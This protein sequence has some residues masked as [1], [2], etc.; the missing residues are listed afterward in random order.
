MKNIFQIIICLL[1]F[2]CVSNKKMKFNVNIE[3]FKLAE[4][5]TDSLMTQKIDTILIF[6]KGCSGCIKG[7]RYSVYVFWKTQDTLRMIRRF[8]NYFGIGKTIDIEDLTRGFFNHESEIRMT[9]LSSRYYW[10]HYDYSALKLIINGH[11]NYEKEIPD[12]FRND[13]NDEKKLMNWL[14]KI[15]SAIYNLERNEQIKVRINNY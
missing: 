7:T 6:T 13:Q 5:F 11:V 1:C 10:S 3:A 12:Y 15:E 2:S 8:D 9:E 14:C 4:N